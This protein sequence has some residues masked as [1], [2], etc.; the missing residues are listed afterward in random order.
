MRDAEGRI[1]VVC[2]DFGNKANRRKDR[3]DFLMF[4][5]GVKK[6]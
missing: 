1:L 6:D 4:V 3:R 2:K 5:A